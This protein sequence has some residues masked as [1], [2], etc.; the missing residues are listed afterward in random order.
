M[1]FSID[2]TTV[3]K[4]KKGEQPKDSVYWLTKTPEERIEAMLFYIKEFYGEAI[5]TQ[6]ME[7]VGRIVNQ[8]T[9][10]IR[11]L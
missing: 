4:H 1:P 8:K 2:K 11:A 6:R 10:E 3:V 7:R 5:F 9:G